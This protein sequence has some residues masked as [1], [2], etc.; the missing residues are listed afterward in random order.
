VSRLQIVIY[1]RIDHAPAEGPSWHELRPLREL[2]T[3]NSS[4]DAETRAQAI[5]DI[6][7][8]CGIQVRDEK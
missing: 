2:V 5:V 3:L 7:P 4:E 8:Y 1:E 6:I